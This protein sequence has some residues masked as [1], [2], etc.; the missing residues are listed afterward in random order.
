MSDQYA[1]RCCK[2]AGITSKSKHYRY[3]KKKEEKRT[4][5]NMVMAAMNLTGPFQVVVSDMTA[6]LVKDVYRALT[7]YMDLWNNE[8]VGYGLSHRKGD[9]NTYFEGLKQVAE[10]IKGIENLKLILLTDQGS[11]YSSKSFNELLPYYR[12]T[13]SIS[14]VGTPT[15]SGA[16][17]AINGWAKVEMFTDF[18]IKETDDVPKFIENYIKFFNEERPSYAL[19]YL[20]P[21]VY[22][23]LYAG[24]VDCPKKPSKIKYNKKKSKIDEHIN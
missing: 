10:K 6:F 22:R 12:I 19:N 24:N 23:E 13:H 16:M 8:I 1:H 20:T 11:V 4:F 3:K 21:K 7:L 2:Y 9:R 17:E 18:K 15:D 5:D 14:R